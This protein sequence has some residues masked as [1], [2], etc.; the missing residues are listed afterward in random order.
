MAEINSQVSAVLYYLQK[1]KGITSIQAF[2]KFGITRLSAIIF[3]LRR[4]GYN[5]ITIEHKGVNRFGNP[6]SYAEYRLIKD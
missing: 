1:H 5:I 4:R 6:V 3:V 2:E